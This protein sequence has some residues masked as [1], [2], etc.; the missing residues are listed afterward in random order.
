MLDFNTPSD[1]STYGYPV[2]VCTVSSSTNYLTC[3][4]G[5]NTAFSLDPNANLFISDPNGNDFISNGVVQGSEKVDVKVV[6][7]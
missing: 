4:C 1:I 6:Y 7:Q 5:S 2:C 3:V